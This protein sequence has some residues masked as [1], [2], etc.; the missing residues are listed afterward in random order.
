MD[1]YLAFLA[2]KAP[3]AASQGMEP[4]PITAP[5]FDFQRKATE[6]C[7]RRGRAALFL[8]TGLGKT[9]CE[10]EFATQAAERTNGK[11]LILTPLA[12][13]RQIEREA[14]RFGY[15]ASVVRDASEVRPGINIC[16]YDR[17]DKLDPSVFGCVVLDELG[18]LKNFAGKTTRALITAFAD[19][20][21]RLAATATPAPNDHVELGTH[22]EFLGIMS[23]AE[24]LVRWFLND[25]NDTGTWRLKGHAVEPFWDWCASWA[26]MAESPEDMGF[27][28]SA[29]VLPRCMSSGTGPMRALCP[30]MACLGLMSVPQPS[31]ISSGK[32]LKARAEA[33]ASDRCY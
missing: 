15:A 9:I 21:F 19:T 17:L 30:L 22:A 20:P 29:F 12:V 26:V 3:V 6:F 25:S 33:V 32:P 16:N 28:G 1:D 18:I 8:D 7:L 23:Q 31:M 13:A 10:L 27:D 24:M 14:T 4:G 5:L 2:G 11:S